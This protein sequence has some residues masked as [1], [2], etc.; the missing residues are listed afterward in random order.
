[1]TV[2]DAQALLAMLL[3]EPGAA[4]VEGLLRQGGVVMA[5]INIAEVI[6]RLHRIAGRPM[7]EVRE[8]LDPLIPTPIAVRDV[9]L[10]LAATAVDLRRRHYNRTTSAL[11]MA[12]CCVLAIAETGHTVVSADGP[13]LRA[14]QAEGRQVIALPDSRGRY[15]SVTG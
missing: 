9:T 5:S 4:D 2:F 8:A 1:M 11:S 10:D 13:L 7:R 3:D 14:A 12:D 15:P 6:D